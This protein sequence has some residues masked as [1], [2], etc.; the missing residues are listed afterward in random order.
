MA[1]ETA[2]RIGINL[3]REDK[4]A[5]RKLKRELEAQYGKLT[6]TAVIRML[7]RFGV[8][9]AS[10]VD[11]REIAQTRTAN[12][13][14]SEE[15]EDARALLAEEDDMG[16]RESARIAAP[17][18]VGQRELTD[19]VVRKARYLFCVNSSEN[20]ADMRAAIEY[21]LSAREAQSNDR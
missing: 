13:G 12:V 6:T 9:R 3:T 15:M 19:E 16:N 4:S 18:M 2:T 5:L 7:I 21:A 11:R 20:D 17:K 14:Y 8:L 10:E 1:K